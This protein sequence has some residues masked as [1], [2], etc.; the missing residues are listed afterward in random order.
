MPTTWWTESCY[1]LCQSSF[2][3]HQFSQDSEC[4]HL[5]D[6]VLLAKDK[7]SSPN[8][9]CWD[10]L[11]QNGSLPTL[12]LK[13]WVSIMRSRE[14]WFCQKTNCCEGIPVHFHFPYR[15]S[16]SSRVSDLTSEDS[17][18]LY[19]A[20]WRKGYSTLLWSDHGTNFFGANREIM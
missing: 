19:V 7:P 16:C 5:F 13:E 9:R 11:L 1:H 8:H 2:S 3:Y 12:S 10:N 18:L 4:D 15:E 6:S 17:S 14:V 20:L